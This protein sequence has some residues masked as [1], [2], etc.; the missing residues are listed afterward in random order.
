VD[1]PDVR[2]DSYEQFIADISADVMAVLQKEGFLERLH[3]EVLPSDS[4]PSTCKNDFTS[5]IR[6]LRS[7]GHD[8]ADIEDVLGVMRSK[9]GFCDC[10]IVF[11]V[12]D[13]SPVREKYWKDKLVNGHK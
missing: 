13:P 3:N 9:G 10:E 8:E 11:N 7:F 6:L 5:A 4:S 12:A 1:A 2:E